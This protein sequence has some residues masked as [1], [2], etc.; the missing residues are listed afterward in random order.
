MN[1]LW[2]L[3]GFM[4]PPKSWSTLNCGEVYLSALWL[5]SWFLPPFCFGSQGAFGVLPVADVFFIYHKHKTVLLLWL[6]TCKSWCRSSIFYD[7]GGISQSFFSIRQCPEG[8]V[9]L[10]SLQFLNIS[11]LES[12]RKYRFT[13]PANIILNKAKNRSK[14]FGYVT[15]AKEEEACKAQIGMNGK[16]RIYKP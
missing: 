8:Y 2:S 3:I 16:A 13:F 7:R 9:L 11:R 14:G 4:K 6:L 15:F 10:L 12:S 1:Y 5:F